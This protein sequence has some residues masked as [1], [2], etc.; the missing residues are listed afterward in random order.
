MAENTFVYVLIYLLIF[1]DF[2]MGS[3][4]FLFL[5]H[6]LKHLEASKSGGAVAWGCFLV[7]K[8]VLIGASFFSWSTNFLSEEERLACMFYFYQKWS[9]RMAGINYG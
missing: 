5:L 1:K 7:K 2:L 4:Q 9:S 3:Q 6:L 8:L